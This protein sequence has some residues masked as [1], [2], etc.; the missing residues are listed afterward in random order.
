M[1]VA[2]SNLGHWSTTRFI[3]NGYSIIRKYK[4]FRESQPETR[5]L[6]E[7]NA[8]PNHNFLSENISCENQNHLGPVGY[9]YTTQKPNTVPLI[10]C[11]VTTTGD[12][13]ITTNTNCDGFQQESIL[14]YAL[15]G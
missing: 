10:R 3:P 8:S 4:V 11:Y 6:F 2:K 12:H 13:F 14:G 1:N 15:L 9:V 5:L 7:C